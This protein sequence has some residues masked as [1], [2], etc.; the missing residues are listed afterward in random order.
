M[1][2]QKQ[3]L[4]SYQVPAEYWKIMD[5]PTKFVIKGYYNRQAREAEA[6]TLGEFEYEIP[7]EILDSFKRELYQYLKTLPEWEEAQDI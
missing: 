1:A 4:T 2:L 6:N 7:L 5:C 3:I